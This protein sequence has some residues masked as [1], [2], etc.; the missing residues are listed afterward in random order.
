MSKPLMLT[1]PKEIEV[2]GI[3]NETAE[4]FVRQMQNKKEAV[5]RAKLKAL[6]ML[7]ILK[8]VNKK[9]FKPIVIEVTRDKEEVWINDGSY[10]GLL[11]VTFLNATE[12]ELKD[13]ELRSKLLYY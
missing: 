13:N 3:V 5:I 9:R 7:H 12:P 11:L 2:T 10:K 8:D 6:N 1:N 4:L